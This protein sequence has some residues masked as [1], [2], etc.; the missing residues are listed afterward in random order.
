MILALANLM[1]D[2]DLSTVDAEDV[3]FESLINRL[4]ISADSLAGLA[5]TAE[6]QC[7]EVKSIILG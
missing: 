5:E 7:L 4:E 2:T 6:Q 1:A 3:R